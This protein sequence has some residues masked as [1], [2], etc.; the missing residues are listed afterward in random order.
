MK[1]YTSKILILI[2]ICLSLLCSC[3]KSNI[4]DDNK[5][6][7][8]VTFTE[9]TLPIEKNNENSDNTMEKW[10]NYKFGVSN[11]SASDVYEYRKL[12]LPDKING[13][14]YYIIEIYDKK[15]FFVDLVSNETLVESYVEKGLYNF[16]DDSY[17]PLINQEK[18]YISLMD[19]NDKYIIFGE[20]I[21]SHLI[22][23]MDAYI[24]L[25]QIQK[26]N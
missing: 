5:F 4:S 11:I 24:I 16:E 25:I 12:N 10:N 26:N 13:Y 8:T 3:N 18:N 20:F 9:F 15:S 17:T 14:K 23:N 1:N 7:E 19:F 22:W 6:S 21:V 2:L